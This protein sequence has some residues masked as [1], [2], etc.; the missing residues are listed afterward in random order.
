MDKDITT[1]ITKCWHEE[2]LVV[3]CKERIIQQ[4]E[5]YSNLKAEVKVPKKPKLQS[6]YIQE[7]SLE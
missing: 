6:I 7:T 1:R 2:P 5:L 4:I 3:L